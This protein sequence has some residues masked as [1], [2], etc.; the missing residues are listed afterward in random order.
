MKKVNSK[1]FEQEV[2]QSALPVLVD[3][4]ADWCGPCRMLGP[5]IHQLAKEYEGKIKV[6]Q[7][8]V[9]QS[10]DLAAAFRVANI[11][12]LL[13]FRGGQ[14]KV[15]YTGFCEKEDLEQKLHTW[16]AL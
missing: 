14:I 8:N 5:I 11:P 13:F 9:D 1:D 12:T 4:Y 10:P 6:V 7:V 15:S 2:L 3:F 16:E